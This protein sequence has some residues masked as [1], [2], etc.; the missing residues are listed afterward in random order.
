[1]RPLYAI[2]GIA[3]LGVCLAGWAALGQAQSSA[4]DPPS[5][6]VLPNVPSGIRPIPKQRPAD[7]LFEVPTAP[8]SN[9]RAL[10]TE[11][12]PVPARDKIE[13]PEIPGVK[14]PARPPV[15]G[16]PSTM[17]TPTRFVPS[18]DPNAAP[19]K[20]A[21]APAVSQLSFQEPAVR[22]EWHGLP[23]LQVG[24]AAEYT[25][26]ARNTSSIPLHK[27]IVQVKVPAG[28]KVA[29]T[30]PKA[31]G[32]DSVLLWDLGTMAARQDRVVKMS[33]IP[34]EKGDMQCQAWV[35]ITGSTYFKAKVS[36]AKLAIASKA[37]QKV[38]AGET[39]AISFVITNLGDH[40]A[41]GVKLTLAVPP[42]LEI[43][44]SGTSPFDLGKLLPGEAREVKVP[45]LAKKSGVHKFD[46]IVE[47]L[48]GIQAKA[49]MSITAVSAQLDLAFTGPKLRDVD[50]KAIYSIK[51]TNTGYANA[52]EVVVAHQL[53][54]GFQFV[55]ADAGG[56]M[57]P[58]TKTILWAVGDL[59][60]G[61]SR[62]LKCELLA[63]TS[64]SFAH[65]VTATGDKGLQSE[66]TLATKIEGLSAMDMEII[67]SDDPVEV[68][69]ETTYEI[70][71]F[72]FGSKDETEVKLTLAI[73]AQMK[74]KAA[75]GPG[76]YKLTANEIIFEP[77]EK[78]P[79]RTEVT[80]RITLTAK[81]KGNAK[82]KATMTASGLTEPI[83][84]QE[85]TKIYAD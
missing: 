39:V 12:P 31:E 76:K 82:F 24:V 84:R 81:E 43:K 34:S 21:P 80:Y 37:P 53:P 16:E 1:M 2:V 61:D 41:E 60:V 51:L 69:T 7:D 49:S 6:G 28:A 85:S 27:V 33:F 64:G 46:A 44:T 52:S 79:A 58:N 73:P 25:L 18:R 56:K 78:L 36:E 23:T 59:A 40:P 38:V 42:G 3:V 62:E 48:G 4:M 45:A 11:V 74:F 55:A 17:V 10:P 47:G 14:R 63:T 68:A 20:P 57:D 50:R 72:N 71:V 54:T 65:K 77:L 35:T 70:R 32:S 9:P 67:D 83:I 19:I 22:L 26:V 13:I 75:R 15:V 66:A 30:E 8:T 29:G 5:P